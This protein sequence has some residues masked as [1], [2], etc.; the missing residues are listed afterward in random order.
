MRFLSPEL[1]LLEFQKR[2]LA[3]AEDRGTP[4]LERLR[5]LGI[6]SANLDEMYM[7]RFAAL[8]SGVASEPGEQDESGSEAAELLARMTAL[9]DEIA[10]RQAACFRDCEP[11]MAARGIAIRHWEDLSDP[12]RAELRNRFE[13]ELLPDLTPLA[14]TLSAGHPL[15]HLPHLSLSI[16]VVFGSDSGDR[17]HLAQLDVP[18]YGGRL[19]RIPGR[20]LET[21]PVEEVIRGNLDMVYRDMEVRG[22]YM[23]RVTRAGDLPLDEAGADSLLEAVA[24]ATGRRDLNPAIRVEVERG[25]P[26]FARELLIR[27]LATDQGGLVIDTADIQDVD[28]LLDQRCLMQLS[29]GTDSDLSYPELHAAEPFGNGV[30]VLDTISEGDILLHHP[31]ESFDG[32]VVRLLEEAAIDPEVTAIKMTLYRVGTAS[33]I[34]D[35]LLAAMRAG[36][37]VAVFVELKARFD[38]ENNVAWARALEAAGA[39]VVYGLVGYKNHAKAALIVRREGDGRLRRYAHIGTGNYNTRTA[40]QYTDLSLF[41]ARDD[42]TADV[43]DLF[44]SLTGS[45]SPPRALSRAALAAPHQLLP[46]LLLRI[47]REAAHARAGRSARIAA[48]INGLSDSEVVKALYAAS[49]AGVIIELIVRGICTLNP[50]MPGLSG[51]IRVVSVLGRLLEHSRIY[52]FENGGAPEHFIGSSDLRPRNLRRRVELLVPVTEP[53]HRARLDQLLELYFADPGGWDLV[54]GGGYAVRAEGGSRAQEM[55][56][57]ESASVPSLR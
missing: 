29:G 35:A 1:S 37:R 26:A 24:T 11:E 16:A 57:N 2:V 33:P 41:T 9:V 20:G 3:L 36:K 27:S 49:E 38:E 45:A 48:K 8:R 22:A 30:R 47:E 55:F 15:P 12:E 5:F 40:R 31:F 51:N 25:M 18:T 19:L 54:A 7:V 44:N 10:E 34:V 23:F 14:V 32:S 50:G 42:L 39:N 13:D 56:V 43:A 4:L 28:G 21:I 52:R 6:V 17:P 46:S 53:L